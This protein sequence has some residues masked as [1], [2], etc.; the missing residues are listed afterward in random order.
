MIGLL[1]FVFFVVAAV[2][3]WLGKRHADAVAYAGLAFLALA[4]IWQYAP[5]A[6]T[7]P[8]P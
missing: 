3:A 1:A 7:T 8:A 6:R 4:G 5:W 2:M